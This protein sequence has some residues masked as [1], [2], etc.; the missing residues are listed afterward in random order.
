MQAVTNQGHLDFD[1]DTIYATHKAMVRKVVKG[2]H[3][4][5][6]TA[7][8]LIQDI[9][10][11]AWTKRSY[12]KDLD[13][14]SGWLKTIAYNQ[15]LN[16]TR[17]QNIQK[18]RLVSWECFDHEIETPENR[19]LFEVSLMQFEEHMEVLEGLI[20]HHG[21]PTR[22][23]IATLFYLDHASIHDIAQQ[24]G[25]KQNTVLSHL[26]RFRLIVTATMQQWMKEH[27]H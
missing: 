8:D 2:F 15:C 24:L 22:R 13:A 20:R 11:L 25:M 21:H 4:Q 14:L 16:L 7:D 26:R 9:F 10:I 23:E 17:L 18:K 12:L 6:A 5:D 3:F 19:T 27:S 1:F